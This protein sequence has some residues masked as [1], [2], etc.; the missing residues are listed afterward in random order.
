MR[1]FECRRKILTRKCE[2]LSDKDENLNENAEIYER[3]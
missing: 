1:I 2:F 3:G